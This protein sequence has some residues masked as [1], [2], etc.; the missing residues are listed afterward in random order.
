MGGVAL[1]R[2]GDESAKEH[3]GVGGGLNLTEHGDSFATVT[4]GGTDNIEGIKVAVGLGEGEF[5]NFYF[6]FE[7]LVSSGALV[8]L[9]FEQN[10]VVRGVK[11]VGEFLEGGLILGEISDENVASLGKESGAKKE[12]G[13]VLGVEICSVDS[14]VVGTKKFSNL[15]HGANTIVAGEDSK[16]V[17][18]PWGLVD[19]EGR[20]GCH[21]QQL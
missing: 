6:A 2:I 17:G 13:E 9:G 16:H 7:L 20:Y 11:I 12:A 3:D 5:L 21:D 1:Q 18:A 10:D 14:F 15:G 19:S 4:L 8:E